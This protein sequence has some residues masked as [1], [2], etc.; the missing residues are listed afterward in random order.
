MTPRRR[1]VAGAPEGGLIVDKPPGMTSHDAVA[2]VRRAFGQPRV[3]HTGTLDP[4]ATGV[5]PLLLGPATRLAQFLT[6]ASKTYLATVRFGQA[7][8]TYDAEGSAIGTAV[9][10]RLDPVHLESILARF[11]GRQRQRPPAVSAKRVGGARSYALARAAAPVELAPVEVEVEA[12]TLLACREREA[13]LRITASAGF[14]VR[15]LAHDLGAA[16]GV[17]AH[18]SALRRERSGGF[19]LDHALTLEQI[20]GQ[21]GTALERLIRPAELLP[22]WPAVPLDSGDTRRIRQGQPVEGRAGSG[23][24]G[25]RVRLLGPDGTLVGLAA[26][27]GRLLHPFLVL[28]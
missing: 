26:S 2:A 25:L 15:S 1:A 8:S 22:D 20:L 12:L 10:V 5:L 3:G 23:A 18:L 28:R 7:T 4:M 21:P 27:D 13:D 6:A 14:Y 11:R 19:T 17:G 24:A 16:M 9:G